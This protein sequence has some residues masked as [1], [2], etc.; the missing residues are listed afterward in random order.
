MMKI[1]DAKKVIEYGTC[2]GCKHE[3]ECKNLRVVSFSDCE[4]H[5]LKA[6]RTVIT[7]LETERDEANE[8]AKAWHDGA[9][10]KVQQLRECYGQRDSARKKN[11]MLLSLMETQASTILSMRNCGNCAEGT[12]SGLSLI[13]IGC[14][15]FPDV[16][17][18]AMRTYLAKWQL[19]K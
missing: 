12:S 16:S 2:G 3:D 6:A 14:H 9:A 18:E 8:N 1:E 4:N 13:C 15:G 10:E 5:K 17:P 19:R 11:M 7:A